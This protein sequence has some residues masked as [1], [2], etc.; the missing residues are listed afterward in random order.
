MSAIWAGRK[1]TPDS[2]LLG[3]YDWH[4]GKHSFDEHKLFIAFVTTLFVGT[5]TTT[6]AE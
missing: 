2:S 1:D 4:A 5:G 3:R 6:H